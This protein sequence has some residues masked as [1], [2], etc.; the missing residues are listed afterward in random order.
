M[1]S[2]MNG[3]LVIMAVG[4]VFVNRPDPPSVFARVASVL[5]QG[6]VV[7]GNYEGLNCDRGSPIVGK[8]EAGSLHLRSAPDNIRAL[9]S[10]GFNAVSLANN[11]NMDYGEEGLLQ[12][13]ALLDKMHIAHAG[14]GHNLE[15]AHRPAI[16]ERNGTRVALLSY[17]SVYIPGFSA[18]E[19]TG[20]LATIRVT[21]SYQPP[22]NWYYQPGFPPLMTTT[23][24]PLDLQRMSNDVRRAR[25]QADIVLVAFHWGVSWGFGKV[26]GYQ[27]ELGRA[28]IDSGADLIMGAHPHSLQPMELYKGKLICYCMGNFVMDGMSNAHFGADTIILKC[29]VK[30]KKISRISF[31]PARISDQWQPYTLDAQESTQVMKKM[32]S[33][34]ADFGTMFSM[35]EGEVVIAGPRPGTPEGRRG[36]SIEPH[37]G[38]P[39]LVDAL[40]LP[41]GIAKK[42]KAGFFKGH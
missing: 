8:I 19:S 12:S 14:G 41:P 27:K 34:S 40:L 16:V 20:G 26:V 17:T 29:Q 35:S 3:E 15:E 7:V 38:L 28:A 1:A 5:R 6:D 25:E 31:I 10:A 21:T 37:R 39:V 32:E 11:H 24:D 33:I 22:D 42:L 9:E 30:N 18:Q 2:D 36:L 13:I 4:D 23:P